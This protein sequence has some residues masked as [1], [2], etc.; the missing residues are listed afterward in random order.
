MAVEDKEEWH[1]G[2]VEME[3]PGCL[4]IVS[5]KNVYTNIKHRLQIWGDFHFL[6]VASPAEATGRHNVR[7]SIDEG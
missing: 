4:E 2:V 7:M 3:Q 5:T 1:D 6:F